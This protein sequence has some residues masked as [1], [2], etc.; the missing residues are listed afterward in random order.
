SLGL[1]MIEGNML[2]YIVHYRHLPVVIG[3]I[4]F[5]T[6]GLG[7]LAGALIA[8]RILERIP[9]GRLI[10][11]CAL[12]GGSATALFAVVRPVP[13]IAAVW[14]VVGAAA[15]IFTVTFYTLRHQLT[16]EHMLGRVV[17]ITRL[18]GFSVLPVAPV[19]GGAIFS[20]TGA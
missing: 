2:A 15:A 8:S 5:A 12:T 3:G 6:L 18:I 17:V 7:A 20:A 13:A 16:P 1:A 11:A 19:I 9:P 4:V 10:I 14:M